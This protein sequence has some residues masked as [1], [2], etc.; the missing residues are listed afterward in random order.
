MPMFTYTFIYCSQ[1]CSNL[2]ELCVLM[3]YWELENENFSLIYEFFCWE[4]YK[5][6]VES[7][8]QEAV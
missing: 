8:K 1:L 4:I 5:N 2:L 6:V 3:W 7:Y